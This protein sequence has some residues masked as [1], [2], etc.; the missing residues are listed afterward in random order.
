[1]IPPC[2][3]PASSREKKNKTVNDAHFSSFG[4]ADSKL[5]KRTLAKCVWDEPSLR[6]DVHGLADASAQVVLSTFDIGTMVSFADTKLDQRI[7]D[8]VLSTVQV[9][10][11]PCITHTRHYCITCAGEARREWRGLLR[12]EG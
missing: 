5:R 6:G 3:P 10:R 8:D 11:G 4:L 7:R 2:L 12:E 9:R 1:M